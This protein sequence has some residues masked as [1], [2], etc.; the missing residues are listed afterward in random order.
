MLL[1]LLPILTRNYLNLFHLS[2]GSNSG[3]DLYALTGWIPEHVYFTEDRPG[4][5]SPSSASEDV[6]DH[7]QGED[8]AW[9]R[10]K[11]AHSFGDCLV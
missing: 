4:R 7:R 3:I 1:R 2:Q 11:S 9:E 5:P 8:R 6:Q 10:I